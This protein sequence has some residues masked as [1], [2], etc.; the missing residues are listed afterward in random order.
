MTAPLL[1]AM[2]EVELR[3]AD[4]A[5]IDA[6]RAAHD[7]QHPLVPA[8]VTFVFPHLPID[9]AAECAHIAAIA[10]RTPPI[11]F[12]LRDA[13]AVLDPLHPGTTHLYLLPAEGE[14]A[15]RALHAA[16]YGGPLAA[17]LRRDL[18]FQPHLTIGAFS[19]I[20]AARQAAAGWNTDGLAIA[21]RIG[22]LSVCRFDGKTLERLER[23]PLRA[24]PAA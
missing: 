24:S 10:G 21:G 2:A 8:H 5:R 9:E 3:A 11:D 18:P 14:P 16:L 23:C 19:G 4:R 6:F 15:M 22:A 12:V 1:L 17:A 20:D 7:P 13:A